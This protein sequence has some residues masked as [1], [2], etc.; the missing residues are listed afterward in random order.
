MK[1]QILIRS[2]RAEKRIYRYNLE[3]AKAIAL[4]AKKKFKNRPDVEVY[5]ISCTKALAPPSGWVRRKIKGYYWCPYCATERKFRPNNRWGTHQC[6]VCG[7][8]TS[9]Y[10]VKTYNH[11][12]DKVKTKKGKK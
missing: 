3:D 12:W 1:F 4:E 8:T 2:P 5:L 7:I 10:W 11:L 9:D 6:T